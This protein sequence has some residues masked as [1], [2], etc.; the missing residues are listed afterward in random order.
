MENDIEYWQRRA[1]E[2]RACADVCSDPNIAAIHRRLAVYYA[3]KA[4]GKTS[5]A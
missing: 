1:S 2:E 3:T 5:L 4:L